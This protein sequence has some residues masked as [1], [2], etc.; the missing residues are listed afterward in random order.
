MKFELGGCNR[1]VSDEEL[2]NDMSL[3]PN[4]LGR[5]TITIA[6]YG[7]VGKAHSKIFHRRR[8]SCV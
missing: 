2:L 3:C 5:E 7:K 4:K 1:G 8:R 6:E